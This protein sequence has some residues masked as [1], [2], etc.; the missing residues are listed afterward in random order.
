[1]KKLILL[2][3][4]ILGNVLMYFIIKAYYRS[5]NFR[6]PYEKW[7]LRYKKDVTLREKLILSALQ[8]VPS[9]IILISYI[10]YDY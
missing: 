5:N 8:Q 6:F 4:L 7:Y 10:T 1:M 3:L 9:A 2:L